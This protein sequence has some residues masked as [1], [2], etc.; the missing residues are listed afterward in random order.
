M[1]DFCTFCGVCEGC[2]K[3]YFGLVQKLNKYIVFVLI[4]KQNFCQP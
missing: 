2:A 3:N 4:I 1:K